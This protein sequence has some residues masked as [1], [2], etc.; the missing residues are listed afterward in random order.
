M[1]TQDAPSSVFPWGLCRQKVLP[2]HNWKV[3]T[4]AV[5]H[6]LRRCPRLGKKGTAL[7]KH[8][9]KKVNQQKM[10]ALSDQ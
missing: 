6:R 7:A 1:L 10:K 2:T 5:A 8:Q 3:D 9:N 4:L